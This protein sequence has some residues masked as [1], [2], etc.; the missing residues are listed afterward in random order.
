MPCFGGLGDREK[1]FARVCV[2][3]VWHQIAGYS[4][5]FAAALLPAASTPWR[6]APGTGRDRCLGS[7]GSG[8]TFVSELL[9][10]SFA[11]MRPSDLI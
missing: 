9:S 1:C 10:F 4:C 7:F 3:Q 2:G 5:W 8:E 6:S 11:V